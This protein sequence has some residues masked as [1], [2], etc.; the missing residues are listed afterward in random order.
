MS[1]SIREAAKQEIKSYIFDKP[2]TG[3]KTYALTYGAEI[4]MTLTVET[5]ETMKKA[6]AL[7]SITRYFEE[8]E[9]KPLKN[10]NIHKVNY[11]RVA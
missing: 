10:P 7:H 6:I 4:V 1:K 8:E 11:F 9:N 5:W 3:W 2:E